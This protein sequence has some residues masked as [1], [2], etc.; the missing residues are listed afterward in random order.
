M[1]L[2]FVRL[3]F[4]LFLMSM[5]IATAGLFPLM[6]FYPDETQPLLQQLLSGN[7]ATGN[8]TWIE[9]LS[10]AAIPDGSHILWGHLIFVYMITALALV[11]LHRNYQGF[12]ALR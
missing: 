9:G 5:M 10:I 1:F 8:A 11:L 6:Q 4:Q 2:R 7:N 3:S 12:T